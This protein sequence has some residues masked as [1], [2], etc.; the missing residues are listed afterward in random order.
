[1]HICC[2]K[3]SRNKYTLSSEREPEVGHEIKD[4]SMPSETKGGPGTKLPDSSTDQTEEQPPPH[5]PVQQQ[6]QAEFSN[7][8]S[9]HQERV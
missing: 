3:L 4:T 2:I 8:H 7:L 6:R 5:C 1:M 9:G